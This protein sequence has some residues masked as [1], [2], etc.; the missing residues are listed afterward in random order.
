MSAF[1]IVTYTLGAIVALVMLFASALA[2]YRLIPWD[3]G[4]AEQRDIVERLLTLETVFQ[5]FADQYELSFVRNQAKLGKL[6]R[7]LARERGEEPEEPEG[8]PQEPAEPSVLTSR[9]D[10]ERLRRQRGL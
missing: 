9:D 8:P 4:N 6:R 2:A 10:L 3:R 7:A 1:E 5:G